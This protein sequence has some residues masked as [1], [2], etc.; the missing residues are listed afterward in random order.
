M[1]ITRHADADSSREEIVSLLTSNGVNGSLAEEIVDG[2]RPNDPLKQIRRCR[3]LNAVTGKACPDCGAADSMG[4]CV[5]L[6][7]GAVGF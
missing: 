5:P 7:R 3:H 2:V 6:P 1:L 4:G